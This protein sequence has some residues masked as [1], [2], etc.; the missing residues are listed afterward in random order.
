[1]RPSDEGVPDE[2]NGAH[3]NGAAANGFAPKFVEPLIVTM[4]PLETPDGEL[5][6]NPAAGVKFPPDTDPFENTDPPARTTLDPITY[7]LIRIRH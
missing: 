5:M 7:T 3:N 1:M 6:L 4:E 2:S